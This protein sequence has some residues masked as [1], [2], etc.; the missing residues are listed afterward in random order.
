MK[1]FNRLFFYCI[2]SLITVYTTMSAQ[3]IRL[4]LPVSGPGWRYTGGAHTH[5]DVNT[6]TIAWSALDFATATGNGLICA[7]APGTV[8][9]PPSWYQNC[10]YVLIDHGHGWMTYYYHVRPI[11]ENTPL[12]SVGDELTRG[13]VFARETSDGCHNGGST[14][15]AHLHFGLI[16]ENGDGIFGNEDYADMRGKY[17]GGWKVENTTDFWNSKLIRYNEQLSPESSGITTIE[18]DGYIGY[19]TCLHDNITPGY[20]EVFREGQIVTARNSIVA[21]NK[22]TGDNI[23][24]H[25]SAPTVTL[26]PPFRID[27]DSKLI[28]RRQP[29][30]DIPSSSFGATKATQEHLSN[31]EFEEQRYLIYPNPVKANGTLTI[32]F[33]ESHNLSKIRI[34]DSKG[35]VVRIWNNLHNKEEIYWDITSTMESKITQG[36]YFIQLFGSNS[37]D[38]RKLVILNN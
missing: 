23:S 13:Q 14:P 20:Y 2:L 25:Y 7:A 21:V 35:T 27:K 38:T 24:V 8:V 3:E 6:T 19:G 33:K 34:I 28:I 29:C 32:Q 4:S 22:I 1:T 31:I 18:N 16:K 36:M 26:L 10:N 37:I 11:D 15:P 9:E 5:N 12:P 30:P 17:I